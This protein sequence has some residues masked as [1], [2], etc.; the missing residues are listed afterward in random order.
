VSKHH[1]FIETDKCRYLSVEVDTSHRNRGP[2]SNFISIFF[3]FCCCDCIGRL[4]VFLGI[5]SHEIAS[6]NVITHEQN[7]KTKY[8]ETLLNYLSIITCHFSLKTL[9]RRGNLFLGSSACIISDKVCFLHLQEQLSLCFV[10]FDVSPPDVLDYFLFIL[11]C[12]SNFR[13]LVLSWWVLFGFLFNESIH[14]DVQFSLI[15]SYFDC[16]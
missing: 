11:L 7:K 3:P 15:N 13:M 9:Q 12:F 4:T 16:V 8:T 10:F 1:A 6:F 2:A 14:I 5:C